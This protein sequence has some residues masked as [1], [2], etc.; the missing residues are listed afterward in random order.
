LHLGSEQYVS[1]FAYT[2][3]D[4]T[5]KWTPNITHTQ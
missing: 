2:S 4:C 3:A 5:Q 1:M